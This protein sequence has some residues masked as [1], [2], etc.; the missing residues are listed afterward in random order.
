MAHQQAEAADV[1]PN[2]RCTEVCLDN[3]EHL[4]IG[5][6]AIVDVL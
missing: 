3:G 5:D 2:N 6:S 4:V 1:Q